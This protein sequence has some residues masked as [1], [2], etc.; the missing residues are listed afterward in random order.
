M[1]RR[2]A[3]LFSLVD[4]EGRQLLLPAGRSVV[5]SSEEAQLKLAGL[6]AR[7]LVLMV[8]AARIWCQRGEHSGPFLVNGEPS[9]ATLLRP[10]D[11]LR[12]GDHVLTVH[13]PLSQQRQPVPTPRLDDVVHE[14]TRQSS[15]ALAYE[16]A[17]AGDTAQLRAQLDILYRL[18]RLTERSDDPA[19]L[20]REIVA[21]VGEVIAARR[22]FCLR[23]G[24][25]DRPRVLAAGGLDPEVVPSITILERVRREGVSLVVHDTAR[26]PTLASAASVA[27]AGIR[28]A[29][30]A[31]L[32]HGDRLLGALYVDIAD[33]ARAVGDDELAL[34][35]SI[36]SYAGVALDRALLQAERELRELQLQLLV[37]DMKNPLAV[38]QGE[39]ALLR[40]QADD[41][42]VEAASA[43]LGSMA[44]SAAQLDGY[45]S[46][47]L[48][49][50][51]LQQGALRLDLRAVDLAELAEDL[52]A[53]WQPMMALRRRAFALTEAAPIT[54]RCDRRLIERVVDNLLT[55]ASEHAPTGTTVELSIEQAEGSWKATVR[56]AGASIPPEQRQQVFDKLG[57]VRARG[58]SGRG[59]GLYFC[60]LAVQAH[61]GRIWAAGEPGDNR[62]VFELPR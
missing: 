18:A 59:F 37:H 19:E 35:E 62:L 54:V 3:P 56:D 17:R 31:P 9:E 49:I 43:S 2:G 53:R 40:A 11:R 24:A 23:F 60:R 20:A 48:D 8:S 33:G 32:R 13:G 44:R 7:H 16:Q 38:I 36:A 27:V 1:K 46:D 41:R 25:D 34:L 52:R 28:S 12:V 61:G 45:V 39:L 10:G 30:C 47:I 21:V 22:V 42:L 51:Q 55:N 29:M 4:D 14:R 58:A 26:D 6:D 15:L 50:A 5:G 57:R